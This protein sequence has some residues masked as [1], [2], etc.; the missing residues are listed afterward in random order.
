MDGTPNRTKFGFARDILETSASEGT[1]NLKLFL[2]ERRSDTPATIASTSGVRETGGSIGA[3]IRPNRYRDSSGH[4]WGTRALPA[5]EIKS[6]RDGEREEEE[7]RR[8]RKGSRLPKGKTRD[9]TARA[10]F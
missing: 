4:T 5:G 8:K 7:E 9:W 6:H 10:R 1:L 2:E 3:Q